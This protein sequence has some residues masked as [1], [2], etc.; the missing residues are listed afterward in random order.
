MSSRKT[1]VLADQFRA[2]G[3]ADP[4]SWAR[5]E[6][7]EGIRQY[8]RF[9]FLRQAWTNVIPDGDTSWIAVEVAESERHPRGPG[10]GIGPALTRMLAA[11]ASPDDTGEDRAEALAAGRGIPPDASERVGD[12]LARIADHE[13]RYGPG[14]IAGYTHATWREVKAASLDAT[15][16]EQNEWA[17]VFDLV[18]RIEY[19]PRGCFRDD[20]IRLVVWYNFGRLVQ[21]V[22]RSRHGLREREG[23]SDLPMRRFGH[24]EAEPEITGELLGRGLDLCLMGALRKSDQRALP[25]APMNEDP[26][27]YQRVEHFVAELDSIPWF[28]NI[29]KPMP[30]D[31]GIER[32][33][34]WEEWLGPEM[35]GN[36]RLHDQQQALYDSLMEEAGDEKEALVALWSRVH[37]AVLRAAAPKVP[38]D[39]N[40]DCYHAPT[41]AVWQAA[42][43]AG[44]VGLC[45]ALGRPVPPELQE[46]WEWFVRGHWPSGYASLGVRTL[47]VDDEEHGPL[48]V[49]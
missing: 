41:L 17:L 32:I 44:L 7:E 42:W 31:A 30:P 5:S 3:A 36:T 46:E 34:R 48:V 13:R 35:P 28:S 2:L 11:G 19:D 45:L 1:Q 23:R 40:Q 24:R 16:V 8:A 10:A 29:G 6:V 37:A 12:D 22:N 15:M 43:T 9:V 47:E 27:I 20:R 33:Y 49:F 14:E 26:E 4:E 39:P 21:L 18:R 38:Y 25:I